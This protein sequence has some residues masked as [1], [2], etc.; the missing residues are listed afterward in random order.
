MIKQTQIDKDVLLDLRNQIRFGHSPLR[1]IGQ[2]NC[3]RFPK[4]NYYFNILFRLF[5]LFPLLIS[6]LFY[7]HFLQF[8]GI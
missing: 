5:F 6:D 7:V 4:F 8:F 2:N 1:S 3:N